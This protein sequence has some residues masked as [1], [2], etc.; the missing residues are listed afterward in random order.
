MGI[1][2][3]TFGH[4]FYVIGSGFAAYSRANLPSVYAIGDVTDRANLT[5]PR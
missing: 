2:F 1:R 5:P 3:V 4:G